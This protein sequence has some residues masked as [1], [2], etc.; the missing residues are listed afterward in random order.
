M[1]NR[2]GARVVLLC[3]LASGGV[4]LVAGAARQGPVSKP[5]PARVLAG[6]GGWTAV[7]LP[8][9][10]LVDVAAPGPDDVWLLTG[11]GVYHWD[12]CTWRA[13]QPFADH[14][15]FM[16]EWETIVVDPDGALVITGE[17][18]A[19]PLVF[20]GCVG[21]PMFDARRRSYRFSPGR[22]TWEPIEPRPAAKPEIEVENAT[23]D[24]E[25]KIV[26]TSGHEVVFAVVERTRRL[27][28]STT[29]T[30]LW[31]RVRGAWSIVL[32]SPEPPPFNDARATTDARASRLGVPGHVRVEAIGGS[33]PQD[34]WAVG[35]G[36]DAMPDILHFDGHTWTS[37]RGRFRPD[38]QYH[39]TGV[40]ST[41]PNDAWVI[42][43]WG[44][45]LH[46]DGKRWI[47]IDKPS[48]V[49]LVEVTATPGFVRV[50]DAGGG[51]FHRAH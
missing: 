20:D 2:A 21:K 13:H 1:L 30:E 34:M 43:A 35:H 26:A 4:L 9:L 37:H 33:G 40:A 14:A 10:Q 19:G 47:E 24:Q 39:L 23:L 11:R 27:G 15:G 50:S 46:W 28:G 49:D 17:S 48:Y 18:P 36:P 45:V 22:S 51:I 32:S 29:T 16:V 31:Q 12:G 3:A 25:R 7:Q 5:A 42:G 41:G 44:T 38:M 8:A 6:C